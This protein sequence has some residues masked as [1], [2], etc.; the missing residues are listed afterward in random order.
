MAWRAALG[1]SGEKQVSLRL[2]HVAQ[3]ASHHAF[4]LRETCPFALKKNEEVC[5]SMYAIELGTL[6]EWE[7]GTRWRRSREFRQDR[8]DMGCGY[9]CLMMCSIVGSVNFQI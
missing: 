3:P 2:T 4:V 7:Y 9:Y 6:H 5:R 8:W 1:L